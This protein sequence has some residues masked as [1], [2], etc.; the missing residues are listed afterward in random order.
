MW[1]GLSTADAA[2]TTTT[3]DIGGTTAS[4][5]TAAAKRMFRAVG[6]HVG[7]GGLLK[8]RWAQNT[9]TAGNPTIVYAGSVLRYRQLT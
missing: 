8:F 1:L 3:T 2:T 6:H 5:G 9:S 4:F 7:N